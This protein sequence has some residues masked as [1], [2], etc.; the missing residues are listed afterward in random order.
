MSNAQ[1]PSLSSTRESRPVREEDDGHHRQSQKSS[2]G[3]DPNSSPP[4]LKDRITE[5]SPP[6]S[7]FLGPTSYSAVFTEGQSHIRIENNKLRGEIDNRAWQPA[8]LPCWDSSK[9]TEGAEVLSLLANLSR[10]EPTLNRWY[11]VQCLAAITFYI[12][13]CVAQIP[14]DLKLSQ[15]RSMSLTTWSHKVFLRTSTPYS[16]DANVSLREYSPSL[17]GENLS[18]ETVG[19]I[20]TTLG[21]SAISMDEVS[22]YDEYDSQTNWKDLAQQLLRAGDQCIAF[23]EQFGHLKDTGVTLIMMNFIL[24]TQVYGD[25]GEHAKAQ[26]LFSDCSD[27]LQTTTAGANQEVDLSL[28]LSSSHAANQAIDLATALFALGLHQEPKADLPFFLAEI[29]RKIFWFA[30]TSD[31]NFATF[32]GRPPLINGKFCSC[33]M[34]L[35][36]DDEK[37]VLEDEALARALAE[38][39]NEG[40]NPTSAVSRGSSLRVSV[41]STKFRE[42]ILELSLGVSTENLE[43]RVRYDKNQ[44]VGVSD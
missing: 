41:I 21:L 34:P 22:V 44:M 24:H 12:R 38:L 37:L 42:E 20:L 29:H 32:F 11:E 31:K 4:L 40:W 1:R 27:V 19:L 39:D 15:G 7:G 16:S 35:D 25:A 14:P 5:D 9:V 26:A 23:C 18:W 36:L 17:M 3:H 10:Y 30:Y 33:K 8:K 43:D 6:V 2:L 28:T 13:E